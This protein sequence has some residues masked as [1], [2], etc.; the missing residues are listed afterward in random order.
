MLG[1]GIAGLTPGAGTV[2]LSPT[3]AEAAGGA[4][5]L[6]QALGV[7]LAGADIYGR[8]FGGRRGT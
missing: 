8:I 6:M 1:Q 2:T 3:P 7:G 4:S 5:P